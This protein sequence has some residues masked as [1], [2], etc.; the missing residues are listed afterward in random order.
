MLR[1]DV[2]ADAL[3]KLVNAEKCGKKQVMLRPSSKVV[4]KVL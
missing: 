4:I 1:M 2:L 3:K